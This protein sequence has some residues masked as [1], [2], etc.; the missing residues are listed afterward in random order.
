V[1]KHLENFGRKGLRTLMLAEREL[2]EQEYKQF[3]KSFHEASTSLEDKKLKLDQCYESVEKDLKLIGATAIEDV[4]Q[5][6]L[7]TLK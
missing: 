1:T 4:L 2:S 7:S 3:S 5:D 6:D